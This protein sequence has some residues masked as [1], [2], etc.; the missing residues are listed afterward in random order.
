MVSAGDLALAAGLTVAGQLNVWLAFDGYYAGWPRP[1]DAVLTA[2]GTIALVWRRREP[3]AVL[4]IEFALF[5]LARAAG[6]GMTFWGSFVPLFVAVFSVAAEEGRRRRYLGIALPVLG[7]LLVLDRPGTRSFNDAAFYTLVLCVSFG[8]GESL[9]RFRERALVLARRT[10]QL[11]LE[12]E[13][14]LARERARIARELHDVIS[15]NLSVAVVQA[16]GAERVLGGAQPEVTTAL[17][18]VQDAGREALAE[19][20]LLLGVLREDGRDGDERAPRPTLARVESLV[21]QVRESGLPVALE[22]TGDPE[23]L[24]PA[25]DLAGYRIVQEALTNTLKHARGASTRVTVACTERELRI[26]VIDE[27]GAH[28]TAEAA[29]GGRGLLGMRERVH[30]HGGRLH[31]GRRDEGGFGVT[32]VIPLETA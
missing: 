26:D 3:L 13:T 21:E 23:R 32:A 10:V 25:V 4:G 2:A 20:Q 5:P 6:A 1:L 18:R 7:F 9:R 8:L 29:G 24:P 11:E 12:Q 31:A 27:G 30:L 22:I 17:R 15:H 19:M 28:T 14:A 16:A